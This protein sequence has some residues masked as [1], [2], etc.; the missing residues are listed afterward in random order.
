[1]EEGSMRC[2]ANISIMPKGSDKFGTRAEI[3]NV[4][5]FKALERALEFEIDRQ[6]ELQEL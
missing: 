3:K 1:M 4:N 5:S 6:I 2:D